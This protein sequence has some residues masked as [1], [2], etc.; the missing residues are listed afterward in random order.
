MVILAALKK[1]RCIFVLLLLAGSFVP[2]R[3]IPKIEKAFN[4]L[5]EF[6]YFKAKKLFQEIYGKK[7]DAYSA[8]GLSEIYRRNDN[9]FHNIDSAG[10]YILWSY[11]HF[12]KN[13]E[14]LALTGYTINTKSIVNLADTISTTF[15][16]KVKELNT[17]G[18]YNYFLSNFYL[19]RKSQLMAAIALRD[20]LEYGTVLETNTSTYTAEFMRQHPQS[21]LYAEAALLLDRQYYEENTKPNDD[22]SYISFIARF[23]KNNLVP[24]AKEN[25]FH[26]YRQKKDTSG[27]AFYV[28]H[29]PESPLSIE[30]WKLLF[31]LTVSDFSFDGLKSFVA[32]YPA[33]TLK[34]SI[35]KELELN[36]LILYPCQQGDYIGYVDPSGK[37]LIKPVYDNAGDFHE[38]LAVVSRNDSVFYI[39]KENN[40]PFK[41]IYAEA[42]NFR[43]GIAPVKQNGKWFFINRQGQTISRTYDEINELSDNLYVVK[44]DDK[45]GALNH[46]GQTVLEPRFEKL[47][48]FT[49]GFAYYTEKG[50][51]GFVSREGNVYKAE[52]EWISEFGT[53]KVAV[54]RQANKFGLV[55]NL[56]KKILPAEYDQV[57][58][59]DSHIVIVVSK[60]LY[61]F[62]SLEGCFLT[63]VAFDFMKEKLADFYTNGNLMKL[64]RKNEQAMVDENGKVYIN[65]GSYQ[66]IHFANNDLLRV[67]QKNKYGYLDKKLN[68]AIPFKYQ[69]AEDF[70][71]S[72]ALVK[73]RDN[74]LLINT[75]GHEIFSTGA[76]IQRVSTHYFLVNDDARTLINHKG[77]IVYT[78]V[79][80]IQ[81]INP[82]LFIITLNN[83]EIKLLSD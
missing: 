56:G 81:K 8:F 48:D 64:L 82:H 15:F 7:H 71:D 17:V 83:A 3:A 61:G 33:F 79:D 80:H 32:R 18:A 16:K 46:F 51:Y 14:E 57:I 60:G 73:F 21:H 63:A 20:E 67:K 29:Y 43:N 66:E 68:L 34:N 28:G 40:N 77:D 50:N 45:Y 72:I 2:L 49:N 42:G 76:E 59:T 25:L 11:H 6:D 10:K 5:R 27:L 23:P 9:P 52:F 78:E 53:D 26:L 41:K 31:S 30:A 74:N 75:Q 19:A 62:Y 39:N 13:P 47:G 1:H 54:F 55:N 24:R 22:Q 38:G 12:K 36:K 69:Q 65:F 35:L 70:R 58:R 44:I 4:A 37:L